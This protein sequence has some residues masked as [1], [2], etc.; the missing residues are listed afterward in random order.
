MYMFTNIIFAF[1]YLGHFC[2]LVWPS[3]KEFGQACV[4][5]KEGKWT[6]YVAVAYY[7][8]TDNI[9]SHISRVPPVMNSLM[10]T[11]WQNIVFRLFWR[12]GIIPRS[13]WGH[14]WRPLGYLV[15]PQ[16]RTKVR[17]FHGDYL[18][19][20]THR[21]HKCVVKQKHLEL[22]WWYYWYFVALMRH[23]VAT[24]DLSDHNYET[25]EHKLNA[26]YIKFTCINLYISIHGTYSY[27]NDIIKRTNYITFAICGMWQHDKWPS[28]TPVTIWATLVHFVIGKW[29]SVGEESIWAAV[30]G[31]VLP[32][33]SFMT[34][35]C[36][37]KQCGG[38]MLCWNSWNP[39]TGTCFAHCLVYR[40]V[41]Y[42]NY[43]LT[44]CQVQCWWFACLRWTASLTMTIK[45]TPFNKSCK[46]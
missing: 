40:M 42:E 17:F 12:P 3:T 43:T 8:P 30:F 38:I 34:I 6:H 27:N 13:N 37:T 7:Y 18:L 26:L 44:W 45:G 21:V 10:E 41:Y 20:L 24:N 31:P 22:C 11:L 4:K 28:I 36:T 46:K 5:R 9:K 29:P 35:W 14:G 32:L 39:Q 25:C 1:Y 16:L 19:H 15:K 2:Q 23:V 33:W